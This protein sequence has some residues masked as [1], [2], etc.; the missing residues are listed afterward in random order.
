M[1]RRQ[2]PE[3]MIQRGLKSSL[4]GI[5]FNFV[6]ALFKARPVSLGIHSPYGYLLDATNHNI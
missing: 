3:Q 2:T 1:A 5:G 4:I 6:L